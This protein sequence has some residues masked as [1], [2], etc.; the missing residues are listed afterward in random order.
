M[1]KDRM[2][3]VDTRIALS[4]FYTI[5][6]YGIDRSLSHLLA[7][8]LLQI[9]TPLSM[10]PKGLTVL[11]LLIVVAILGML[12]LAAVSAIRDAQTRTKVSR[13]KADLRIVAAGLEMYAVDQTGFPNTGDHYIQ[14][15][16]TPVAYCSGAST[17]IDQYPFRR[18]GQ[19]GP[20]PKPTSTF[21]Y[22]CFDKSHSS[23]LDPGWEQLVAV[24]NEYNRKAYG[25]YALKAG[26]PYSDLPAYTVE[27]FPAINAAILVSIPY[28]PTNGVASR[29]HVLRRQKG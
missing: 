29:G 14:R 26:G 5:L 8:R 20:S 19:R 13:I 4:R 11:E 22:G 3:K 25:S 7:G 17:F 15:L 24:T 28:D 23:A 21:E 2:V 27:Q 6:C 16:T 1:P 9:P 10:K 12:V 18:I